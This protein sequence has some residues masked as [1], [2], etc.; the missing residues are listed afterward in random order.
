MLVITI[1]VEKNLKLLILLQMSSTGMRIYRCATCCHEEVMEE[2]WLAHQYEHHPDAPFTLEDAGLHEYRTHSDHT[3]SQAWP[4]CHVCHWFSSTNPIR[5]REH[6]HWCAW[7]ERKLQPVTTTPEVVSLSGAASLPVAR[8]A[9]LTAVRPLSPTRTVRQDSVESRPVRP[10]GGGAVRTRVVEDDDPMHM[11]Q[12]LAPD[13]RARRPLLPDNRLQNV[14]ARHRG[15][16]DALIVAPTPLL[17]SVTTGRGISLRHQRHCTATQAFGHGRSIPRA[18]FNDVIAYHNRPALLPTPRAVTTT[19]DT[20]TRNAA[21]ITSSRSA[22]LAVHV[23][24]EGARSEHHRHIAAARPRARASTLLL[25][26]R[27]TRSLSP[28]RV[29]ATYVTPRTVTATVNV[30][31]S[32]SAATS[33]SVASSTSATAAQGSNPTMRKK[34]DFTPT[35]WSALSKSQRRRIGRVVL[36]GGLTRTQYQQLRNRQR[37]QR[38]RSGAAAAPVPV[39]GVPVTVAVVAPAMAAATMTVAAP[40]V[41]A[42]QTQTFLPSASLTSS[43]D[44]DAQRLCS[45]LASLH[46]PREDEDDY[47]APDA[48]RKRHANVAHASDV[49]LPEFK[50]LTMI[51]ENVT[52]HSIPIVEVTSS[53]ADIPLPPCASV[54]AIL[55]C[56]VITVSSNAIPIS[57]ILIPSTVSSPVSV[58]PPPS[59]PTVDDYRYKGL[60]RRRD[61][62]ESIVK[63]VILL[64]EFPTPDR[65]RLTHLESN[66][67]HPILVQ[68]REQ[69]D[70]RY[71]G[72]AP[73]HWPAHYAW[74]C[75][76][77]DQQL[78]PPE[79]VGYIAWAQNMKLGVHA[80]TDAVR[81][82]SAVRVRRPTLAEKYC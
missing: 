74:F 10:S 11:R 40:V 59:S 31:V 27:R 73:H 46:V 34:S 21:P 2:G 12:Y 9:S 33:V 60:V 77:F 18:R 62:Q 3:T 61:G 25:V 13:Y 81:K 8:V 32:A 5:F 28:V 58:P 68:H 4:I 82:S 67:I 16:L 63:T 20:I 36:P 57:S 17:R 65:A 69:A 72:M 47:G 75:N 70:A 23:V 49:V 41:A 53:I 51:E 6:E 42:S 80:L 14:L 22:D 54:T 35:E 39:V 7:A 37:R 76:V 56:E 26:P 78:T 15:R 55:P 66:E 38:G 50:R 48:Q 79:F 24:T 71:I 43:P 45:R 1:V 52:S 44:E 30:S 19:A 64:R 29:S